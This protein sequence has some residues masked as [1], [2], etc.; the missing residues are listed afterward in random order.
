MYIT[1][2]GLVF[3]KV[4]HIASLFLIMDDIFSMSKIVNIL[5]D[6]VCDVIT[7]LIQ[8]FHRNDLV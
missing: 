8:G 3:E 4:Y 5:C 6:Q 2:I 1:F 7:Y